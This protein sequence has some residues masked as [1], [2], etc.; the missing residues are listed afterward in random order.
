ITGGVLMGIGAALTEK[1]LFDDK[2]IMKTSNLKRYQIPTLSEMPDK[3]TCI[4]IENPQPNGPFGARPIAEH[5]II[6]PPP[7]ILNAFQQA[8]DISLTKLPI[9]PKVVLEALKDRS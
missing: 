6:G 8:T 4:L 9:S 7:A 3:Y 2:G 1:I 5:P